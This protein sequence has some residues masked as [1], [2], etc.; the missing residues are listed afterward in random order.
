MQEARRL[1]EKQ[2]GATTDG[3]SPLVEHVATDE[4]E[5][6]A[7]AMKGDTRKTIRKYTLAELKKMETNLEEDRQRF[8]QSI[9]P[10]FLQYRICSDAMDLDS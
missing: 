4:N 3:R 9:L 7:L 2:P 8:D 10:D 5:E 6:A 1:P